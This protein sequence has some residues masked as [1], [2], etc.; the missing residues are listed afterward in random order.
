MLLY[1]NGSHD[2]RV[3]SNKRHRLLCDWRCKK[4]CFRTPMS[5]YT[6]SGRYYFALHNLIGFPTSK[7]KL[8]K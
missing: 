5:G 1:S 3:V 7:V 2:L 6:D 8:V 4:P